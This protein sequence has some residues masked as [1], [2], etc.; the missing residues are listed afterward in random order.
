M[1]KKHHIIVT[2]VACLFFAQA[3][4]NAQ[5][6]PI[7]VGNDSTFSG[8][9]VYG[10]HN[11]LVAIYGDSNSPYTINAQLIGY[12]GNLIGSRISLNDIGVF[13]GAIPIFDGTNYFLVWRE[14][15]GTLKGQFIDT[16]GNLLGFSF[17]IATNLATS[18][19]GTFNIARGDTVFLV[20]FIKSDN[21]LYGQII[22]KSGNLIG[23]QI[24]ISIGSARENA[25]AFDGSNFL[26]AWVDGD[27]NK[28]I[29]GQFVSKSGT[30]VGGNFL[31]DGGPYYSDNP[32]SLAFDGTKYLLAYHETTDD[33]SYFV[34]W[35]LLGKFI[36]TSGTIDG[37]ITICDTTKLPFLPSVAF[38][39]TNYLITW[40]Q[41]L[42]GNMMGRF[43]NTFGAPIDTPFVIFGPL[44]NKIP[45]GGVGFGGGSYL[46]VATRCNSEFSDGDVYGRFITPLV[47]KDMDNLILR[48]Y[49]DYT[50]PYNNSVTIEYD[51]PKGCYVTLRIYNI[52]GQEIATLM[53]GFSLAG[54]HTIQWNTSRLSGG[55]YF[56]SLETNSAVVTQKLILPR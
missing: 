31:I 43:Y 21:H 49:L 2:M 35:T 41:F 48:L 51:L 29:Y 10:G 54:P 37:T 52:L 39:G 44:N 6:F 15:N 30:L 28:D 46:A 22:S 4:I 40:T 16:A 36:S 50:T 20:T 38:D 18:R 45:V 7:A 17:S 33:T 11:G 3:T 12:P 42:D 27:N 34:K 14:F 5:E 55:L 1:I 9:A 25:V 8:G 56:C 53:S 23:S 19:P 32:V 26:V 13:P 24:Q 47:I